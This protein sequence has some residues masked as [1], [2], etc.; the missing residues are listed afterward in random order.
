M[1]VTVEDD[2]D[3]EAIITSEAGARLISVE[4]F[5]EVQASAMVKGCSMGDAVKLAIEMMSLGTEW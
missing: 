4:R 2:H 1:K 3:T 5:G